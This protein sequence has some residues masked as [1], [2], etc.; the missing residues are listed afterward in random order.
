MDAILYNKCI[1]LNENISNDMLSRLKYH[2]TQT[3]SFT[4]FFCWDQA[5]LLLT[6]INVNPR[7]DK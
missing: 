5:P 2:L 6:W 7:M 1:L 3:A 4:E